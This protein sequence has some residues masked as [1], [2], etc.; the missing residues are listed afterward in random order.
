MHASVGFALKKQSCTVYSQPDF[1]FSSFPL[2]SHRGSLLSFHQRRPAVSGHLLF[3]PITYLSPSF[4]LSFRLLPPSLSPLSI[5]L[6]KRFH[7]LTY[8]QK[9][10]SA[11]KQSLSL[12]AA[13]AA[14][15]LHVISSVPSLLFP[16]LTPRPLLPR[17]SL[18]SPPSLLPHATLSL[19]SLKVQ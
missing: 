17:L 1:S 5:S 14:G 18:L 10:S 15:A 13:A 3:Q 8:S 19:S 7:I 2:F 11:V 9:S 6:N 16:S 12:V 4:S